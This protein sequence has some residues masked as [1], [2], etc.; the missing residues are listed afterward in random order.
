MTTGNDDRKWDHS[1]YNEIEMDGQKK[2]PYRLV[3]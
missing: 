3:R 1:K 2:E